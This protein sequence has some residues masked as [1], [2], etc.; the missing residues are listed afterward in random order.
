[1]RGAPPRVRTPEEVARARARA[2]STAARRAAVQQLRTERAARVRARRRAALRRWTHRAGAVGAALVVVLLGAVLVSGVQPETPAAASVALDLTARATQLRDQLTATTT[3]LQ[4]ARTSVAAAEADLTAAQDALDAA[5]ATLAAARATVGTGADDLYRAGPADRAVAAGYPAGTDPAVSGSLAV[6][7]ERAREQLAGATVTAQSAARATDLAAVRVDTAAAVLADAR[8]RV[9]Q[10]TDAARDRA[11]ALEP[12]VAIAL[13]GLAGGPS[14][15]DQQGVDDAA[16]AGWQARLTAIAAAGVTL[17]TAEQLRTG[18]L[19]AGLT[20]ARDAAGAEVPGVAAGVV[21]GTVVTIPSAEAAAAV[22]YAF[23]QLGTPFVPG[24]TT[25]AGVDCTGLAAVVWTAAGTALGTGLLDQWVA[26]VV[27]PPGQLQAGDLVFGVDPLAGLDDVGVYTGDGSVVTASA[28]RHQVVVGPLPPGAT[29]IRVTVPAESPNAA[30]PGTGTLP[31]TCGVPAAQVTVAAVDPAWGGYANGRVPVS[32]LC[33]IGGGHLLRCDAAGAYTALA[34]AF[35]LQ[36]GTPLCI[37]D[38]YRSFA[39]QQD[40]HARKPRITAVPGTSNHGWALAVDLCGGVNVF[41]SAQH[42]W[43]DTYAGWFG[44][45]HPD[46]AQ[47]TG[48]NPEPW[49][50]E[51]GNLRS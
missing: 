2:S 34:Q 1:M 16:R 13:T 32:A 11:G 6:A 29:G 27:V 18:Q 35:Q 5:Q 48:E 23:A 37:T 49:H 31:V 33:P 12:G 3:D 7:A 30:P 45:V 41:G 39:A 43:M 21:G 14:A 17:P 28:Q 36:F 40:A 26:G 51:F 24:G 22:S 44:W 8:A 9:V 25:P 50:W 42:D 19:P 15:P 46:W 10:V 20:P 4:T 47:R 38:S